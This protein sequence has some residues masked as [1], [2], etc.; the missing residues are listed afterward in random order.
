M[1]PAL[2]MTND[3][4]LRSLAWSPE[5]GHPPCFQC[6]LPPNTRHLPQPH[7]NGYLV[8]DADLAWY[9]RLLRATTAG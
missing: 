3:L 9:L 8:E 7:R 5:L 4:L 6:F 2:T 1:K